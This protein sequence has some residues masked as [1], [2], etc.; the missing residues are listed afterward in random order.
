MGH[1]R[2]AARYALVLLSGLALAGS[3][4]ARAPVI[5]Y[6]DATSGAFSLYDAAAKKALPAPALRIGGIV[7]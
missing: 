2:T 4:H 3:A 5:A 6:V 1:Y 7:D